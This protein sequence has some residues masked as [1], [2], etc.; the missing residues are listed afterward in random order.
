MP[1]I[2]ETVDDITSPQDQMI[3][4]GHGNPDHRPKVTL[5]EYTS[6]LQM[7][8]IFCTCGAEAW[9]KAIH[10]TR[11]AYHSRAGSVNTAAWAWARSHA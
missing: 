2:S 1:E 3:A 5:L 8:V 6:E 11:K 4:E 9:S 7:I 10:V